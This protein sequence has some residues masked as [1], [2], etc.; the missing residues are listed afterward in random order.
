MFEAQVAAVLGLALF[1]AMSAALKV[2]SPNSI[3]QLVEEFHLVRVRPWLLAVAFGALEAAVAAGLALGARWAWLLAVVLLVF[4]TVLLLVVTRKG[5][6]L[7]CGC[8]GDL[9]ESHVGYAPLF[10]NVVLLALVALTY[11]AP[12]D[13]PVEA[14]P[15]ALVIAVLLVLVP[16]ATQIVRDLR[17][18]AGAE[19][20]LIRTQLEDL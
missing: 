10:R 1:F 9:T 2:V 14:L 19:V 16:D 20:D 15:S 13:R 5:V 3:A 6:S 11:G 8:L 4:F 18:S 12:A 17:A 7:R